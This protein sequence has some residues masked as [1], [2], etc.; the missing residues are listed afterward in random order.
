MMLNLVYILLTALVF[1][2]FKGD[3]SQFNKLKTEAER[4]Y[5]AK[6]YPKAIEKYTYLRDS[7]G[8]KDE[9]LTVNLAHSYFESQK[10]EE[11]KSAYQQLT[12]SND[13]SLRSIAWQ[14]LGVMEARD[15]KLDQALSNFKNALR[16]DPQNEEAR[17]NYELTRKKLEEQK[18]QNQEENQDKDQQQDQENQ[19]KK[20][21]QQDKKESDQ[22]DQKGDQNKDDKSEEQKQK[23]QNSEKS[24]EEKKKEEQE[25]QS[26]EKDDAE[27][28][29]KDDESKKPGEPDEQKEL[30]EE[31]MKE[32]QNQPNFDN[33][34][35]SKEMAE[36]IL[37][38][39]QNNEKQYLQQL[40][41]KA[42]KP[43]DRSKPDW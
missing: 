39:L 20:D 21:G 34:E 2:D 4:A 41:R 30:T 13:P 17:Y 11:A 10:L 15:K 5:L 37:Q 12:V 28:Q 22:N 26:E 3:V 9:D 36:M 14:Q 16:S 7:L 19:D 8:V 33:K 43:A 35:I 25:G 40:K 1:G 42:N 18:D 32:L 29:E 38:A 23:E 24:E 27:K 31:Q 6:E